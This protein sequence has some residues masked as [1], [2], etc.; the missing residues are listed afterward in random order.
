LSKYPLKVVRK[1]LVDVIYRPNTA[2]RADLDIFT[3][4]LHGIIDQINMEHKMGVIMGDMNVDLLKHTTHDAT[5]TYVDG[6]YSR[7]FSTLF[8]ANNNH[9]YIDNTT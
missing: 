7:G 5:D 2:S 9:S 3:T 4:P 1:L 8:K 6:I